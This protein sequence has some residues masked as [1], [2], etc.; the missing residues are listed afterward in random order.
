MT[1]PSRPVVTPT[2][3]GIRLVWP[4]SGWAAVVER[5]VDSGKDSYAEATFLKITDGV[6]EVIAGPLDL[7]LKS[8]SS[9]L[10]KAKHLV[11]R[12]DVPQGNEAALTK[13]LGVLVNQTQVEALRWRRRP[14]TGADLSMAEV[15][16]GPAPYLVE[17][18]VLDGATNTL[19][20]DGSGGKS[21]LALALATSIVLNHELVPGMA[22]QR[23]GPVLYFDFEWDS[24]EHARRLWQI[25]RGGGLDERPAGIKHFAFTSPLRHQHG[26]GTLIHRERPSLV[27]V[28]SLGY[29]LGG[30]ITAQEPISQ[31]FGIM[32]SW[33]CTV[34]VLHHE[35][36]D[37]G[38]FGSIY[39]RNSTRNM[40]AMQSIAMGGGVM[41][42]ELKHEKINGGELYPNKLGL[43]LAFSPDQRA[44]RFHALEFRHGVVGDDVQT[45][46]QRLRAY[47]GVNREATATQA[48]REIRASD[49]RISELFQG[50]GYEPTRKV[51]REQYYRAARRL[52]IVADNVPW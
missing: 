47:M 31:A 12:C 37:K 26:L 15:E 18:L 9:G 19:V 43:R 27:I 24:R 34:L 11:S 46:E 23:S 42:M 16:E 29:A 32:R 20:A 48:S 30:D 3:D 10:S 50:A 41:H 33:G 7:N 14:P 28:D 36:R 4:E 6:E 35:N 22:P 44:L 49:S 2:G 1:S 45:V 8:E 39:I 5:F 25:C 13:Y 38:F 52:E 51:G 17:H 40:W 21:Y